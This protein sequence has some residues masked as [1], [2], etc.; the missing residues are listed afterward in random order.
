MNRTTVEQ[1]R[2]GKAILDAAFRIHTRIGPGLLESAYETCLAY[3]LEKEGFIA[4]RQRALPLIYEEVKLDTGYRID[5]LVERSVIVEVK[6]VEKFAPVHEA[7]LLTYMRLSKISL[8]FL[9]NFYVPKMK[10]GIKRMI[11]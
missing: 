5:L 9:L 8:G 3:E 11:L 7:Q 2:V 1:E 10:D 4:E 6:T